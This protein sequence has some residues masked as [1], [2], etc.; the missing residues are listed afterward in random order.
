MTANT[1]TDT[2]K[3]FIIAESGRCVACGLCL[4]YCPTYQLAR[5][6]S[7]SPRGRISLLAALAGEE[8]GASENL[9]QTLQHCLLCGACEKMCPSSVPFARL[10]DTGRYLHEQMTD[11][12]SF[13][14]ITVRK[15]IDFFL[16]HPERLRTAAYFALPLRSLYRTKN[17]IKKDS[18]K[19]KQNNTRPLLH[20]LPS[21]QPHKQWKNKYSADNSSGQV[22]LFLGC[23]ARGLDGATIDDA[24]NVLTRIGYSV[25]I[26]PQQVCC[27]A[28]S[29][30]AGRKNPSIQMMKKNV[31]A[32]ADTEMPIIHTASGC[33]SV[34]S[35]YCYYLPDNGFSERINEVCH[36]LEAHW[37]E[38]TTLSSHNMTV[39]LHT[40]CSVEGSTAEATAAYRL[41]KR[42]TD[43]DLK[44]VNSPYRCCGASGTRMLTDYRTSSS[45][46]DP[47]VEQVKEIA[48]DMVIS[49]NIG[50]LLHLAEGLRGAGLDIPVKHPVSLIADLLIGKT[51]KDDKKEDCNI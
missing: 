8:L 30:H 5:I 43:I 21:V 37:P 19:T 27:G 38:Q 45:L 28:L 11:T 15:T 39:L 2:D 9:K 22:G 46:R 42:F 17:R 23:V 34:L 40:P 35:E 47:V 14:K 20:Y 13:T 18:T 3:K 10:M 25:Y 44:M 31:R 1:T 51:R 36:F 6:E 7:E 49:S 4:P 26:P 41:L 24:I 16:D 32:F 50:C 29:L 12:K 48:P 33:G